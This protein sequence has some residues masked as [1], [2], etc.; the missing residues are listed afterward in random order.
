MPNRSTEEEVE[1]NEKKK[2]TSTLDV[3]VIKEGDGVI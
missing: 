3:K 2:E 1:G